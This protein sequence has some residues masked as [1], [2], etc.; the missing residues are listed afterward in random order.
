MRRSTILTSAVLIALTATPLGVA[1][2]SRPGGGQGQPPG[3][4]ES[5]AQRQQRREQTRRE[6]EGGPQAPLSGRRNLGPCPYVKVLYDAGRYVELE[7]GREAAEA[8]GWTG[9]I[10]GIQADCSYENPGDPIRVRMSV[11][12]ALGRGPRAAGDANTYRW[13]VAVTERNRAVL[14]REDFELPAQF[15]GQ[16]RINMV[17]EIGEITLPRGSETVSGSNYEILVGFQVTPAMAEFNR[18]GKRFRMTAG[19]ATIVAATESAP[20]AQ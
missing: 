19:Q 5:D 8:V 11:N 2:Q 1:A 20:P 13:W 12:F 17:E 9:E 14:S 7:G 16:D 18:Q 15:E 3:G 10:Q 6:F 4:Q